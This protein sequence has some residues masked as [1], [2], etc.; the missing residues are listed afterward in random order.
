ME[1]FNWQKPKLLHTK[2]LAKL[3][4]ADLVR[5]GFVNQTIWLEQKTS[6]AYL[7]STIIIQ[8]IVEDASSL[9]QEK[10]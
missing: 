6:T 4:L 9:V 5:H 3:A 2:F 7:T 10:T 8:D 1:L